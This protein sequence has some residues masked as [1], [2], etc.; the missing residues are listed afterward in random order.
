MVM[1]LSGTF[2]YIVTVPE[3]VRG[4]G[5]TCQARNRMP[6]ARTGRD[7]DEDHGIGRSTPHGSS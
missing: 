1:L 4:G 6:I 5:F 7:T 3:H 2:D